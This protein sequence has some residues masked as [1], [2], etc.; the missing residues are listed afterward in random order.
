VGR[1]GQLRQTRNFS[2]ISGPLDSANCLTNALNIFEQFCDEDVVRK[3]VTETNR[4]TEQLKNS[5]GSNF[6]KRSRIN[7]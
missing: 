3:I 4:Y 1:H 7:E 5:R 6:S 2:E